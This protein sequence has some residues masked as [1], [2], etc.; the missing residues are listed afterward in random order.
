VFALIYSINPKYMGDFFVDQRLMI[1]GI[2]GI[3]WMAI[4]AG[5]MAKM[6]NFE[7]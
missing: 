5:I 1:A 7:I 4:G 2:G 3:F 6:I